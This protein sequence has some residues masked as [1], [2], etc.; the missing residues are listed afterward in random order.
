MNLSAPKL[1]AE[2]LNYVSNHAVFVREEGCSKVIK[3]LA[4]IFKLRC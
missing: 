1:S 2:S 3:A 4:A